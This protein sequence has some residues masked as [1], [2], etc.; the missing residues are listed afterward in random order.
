MRLEREGYGGHGPYAAHRGAALATGRP[1]LLLLWL[2]QSSDPQDDGALHFGGAPVNRHAIPSAI[3]LDVVP[4]ALDMAVPCLVAL[5]A[6][7]NPPAAVIIKPSDWRCSFA[8]VHGFPQKTH[9]GT[10]PARQKRRTRHP[11]SA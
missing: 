1:L 10:H 4:M 11:N 9:P 3:N 7:R 6:A 8:L 5:D 2:G